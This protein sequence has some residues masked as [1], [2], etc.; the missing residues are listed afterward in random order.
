VATPL[1]EDSSIGLL[2][3]EQIGALGQGI[4]FGKFIIRKRPLPTFLA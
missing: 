2:E 3:G 1:E 4:K